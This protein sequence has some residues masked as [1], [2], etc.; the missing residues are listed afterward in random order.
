MHYSVFIRLGLG[1]TAQLNQ[2]AFL[3]TTPAYVK[4]LELT[5]YFVALSVPIV[6]FLRTI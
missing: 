3:S 5:T 4:S 2:D 1:L 6:N